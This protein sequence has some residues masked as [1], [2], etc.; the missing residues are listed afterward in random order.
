MSI[1]KRKNC[2]LVSSNTVEA[3]LSELRLTETRV[4]RNAL[5]LRDSQK[6]LPRDTSEPLPSVCCEKLTCVDCICK[7]RTL[8]CDTN[9][10][11]IRRVSESM[12]FLLH[13]ITSIRICVLFEILLIRNR[14]RPLYFAQSRF[15][16][17]KFLYGK[18]K[19]K[20]F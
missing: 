12:L 16:C 19:N 17:I 10:I 13:L 7:Y 20:R 14:V 18:W 6:C 1:L 9:F 15:Y 4:N 8:S 11:N 5:F 3:R 2:S